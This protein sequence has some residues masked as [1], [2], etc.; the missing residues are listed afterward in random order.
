[1]VEKQKEQGANIVYVAVSKGST[2]K[3][4]TFVSRSVS[5]YQQFLY[6]YKITEPNTST[7]IFPKKSYPYRQICPIPAFVFNSK[8]NAPTKLLDNSVVVSSIYF[9]SLRLRL[10]LCALAGMAEESEG[11]VEISRMSSRGS[12][13]A[14]HTT[15]SAV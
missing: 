9:L 14:S 13:L 7:R 10:S 15:W 12:P 11:S 6:F 5:Q 2:R 8:L 4:S 3:S 1:M